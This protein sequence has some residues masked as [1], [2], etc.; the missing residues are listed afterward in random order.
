LI[1]AT[2]VS[3]AQITHRGWPESYLLSNGI[4]EAIVVPAIGRVMQFR[5]AGDAVGTLWENHELDGKLHI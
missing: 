2:G 3:I 1:S 4:V 5:L